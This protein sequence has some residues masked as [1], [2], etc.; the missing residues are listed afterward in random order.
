MFSALRMLFVFTLFGLPAAIVGIPLSL[1][2]G[3]VRTM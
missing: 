3:N 2:R 1:L